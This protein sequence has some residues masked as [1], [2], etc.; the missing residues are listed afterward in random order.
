MKNHE[1]TIDVS[2]PNLGSN[3]QGGAAGGGRPGARLSLAACPRAQSM[4][5]V[6]VGAI[7]GMILVAINSRAQAQSAPGGSAGAGQST[8]QLFADQ[9]SP[10]GFAA[11]VP[12][13]AGASFESRPI[14]SLPENVRPAVDPAQSAF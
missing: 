6:L 4:G 13:H 9:N 1:E 8:P 3:T 10:Q 5:R 12:S 2:R 14:L 7:L 11:S